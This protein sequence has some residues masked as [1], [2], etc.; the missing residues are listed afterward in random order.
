MILRLRPFG[1][2]LLVSAIL[3]G[4][5]S[6]MYGNAGKAATASPEEYCIRDTLVSPAWVHKL[7]K[8]HEAGSTSEAPLGYGHDRTHKYLIFET[9][10]GPLKDAAQYHAGHVPGA[11]HSNSD[12]YENGDPR[13]FLQPAPEIFA[14]MKGM[15]ITADTTVVVYSADP[16]FAARLWWILKYAGLEDVRYLDGGYEKWV[17]D[18]FAG[19]T[20]VNHPTAASVDYTGPLK[21]GF[22]ASVDYVAAHHTDTE[23]YVLADVRDEK[24]YEGEASGY[25]YLLAK[26][27]IP[28]AI[29]AKPVGGDEDH[30]FDAHNTLKPLDEIA[31]MWKEIG[32]TDGS[33][34]HA[35]N[36]E[37][38]FYCGGGYRSAAAFLYAHLMGYENIRNLSDGWAGWST[39]YTHD[40]S[41]DC[42][43]GVNGAKHVAW[44]SEYCQKPSGRDIVP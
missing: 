11:I 10:W 25:E 4:C 1:T 12:I 26:G 28:N 35:F 42:S 13:W 15:G 41:S 16:I 44:P 2:L 36:K 20:R 6:S 24:E 39:T 14:A 7:I 34:P 22:I 3:V 5:S 17:A 32:V 40:L 23:S 31:A 33:P 27:R 9:S 8:Y 37:I 18:G 29:W 38:I 21:P 43:G 30:Y 19:E